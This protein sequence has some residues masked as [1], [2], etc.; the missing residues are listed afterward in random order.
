MDEVGHVLALIETG[1]LSFARARE[2][3]LARRALLARFPYSLVFALGVRFVVRDGEGRGVGG[4]GCGQS[5]AGDCMVAAIAASPLDPGLTVE[6]PLMLTFCALESPVATL[7]KPNRSPSRRSTY[8]A[9]RGRPML[10]R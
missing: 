5:G 8:A 9:T 6:D 2:S 3:R 4:V 1:P 10:R 7:E